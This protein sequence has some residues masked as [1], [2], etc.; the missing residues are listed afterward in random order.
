[1]GTRLRSFGEQKHKLMLW[2]ITR[3]SAWMVIATGNVIQTLVVNTPGLKLR[4]LESH[5]LSWLLIVNWL[6]GYGIVQGHS[7]G[8]GLLQWRRSKI[9]HY[10][11][12]SIS[13]RGF[14][15]YFTPLHIEYP[16]PVKKHNW[17]FRFLQR[18]CT[19]GLFFVVVSQVDWIVRSSL[20]SSW[21]R[22]NIARVIL[23][24]IFINLK[25]KS[26]LHKSSY[27]LCT[28]ISTRMLQIYHII[29]IGTFNPYCD[30]ALKIWL[31]SMAP[32]IP[33]L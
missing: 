2:Q 23:L 31:V 33:A 17:S 9:K 14:L 27:C 29:R 24:L 15:W 6:R 11:Q 7:I 22:L 18:I 1:M 3:P 25:M 21:Y 26:Y 10:I 28:W 20:S 16:I 12:S 32:Y 30:I 19:P 13:I 8:P 4:V 5:F